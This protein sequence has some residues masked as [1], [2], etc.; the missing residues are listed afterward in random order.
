MT[1]RR[2]P[3]QLA[4]ALIA[5]F[6]I[7]ALLSD[8]L[9]VNPP[10][11]LNLERFFAPP[12]RVRFI[13]AQGKFHWRP[14]VC[15]YE[16]ADP[17]DVR[18]VEKPDEI[19]PLSFFSTGYEYRFMG[20]FPANR[21][22]V[23][24]GAGRTFYPWGA[25][26]L[27]RDVLAR[28]LAGART[29]MIVVIVGV[30]VYAV[31]GFVVGTIAGFLRGWVDAALMR[32]SE[33]VMAVPA[34]Y[35]ILAL[36]A[37]LPLKLSY[38]QTVWLVAG[39]I[40]S[41]TWPPLA[42]GIRGLVFQL[43]NAGYVESARAAGCTP[44]RIFRRHMLPALIPFGAA[45]TVI[46]APFFLLGEAVLSFLDIGFRDSGESWGSMLRSLKDPRVLTGFWWNLA[47]LALI[48]L[49][50]LCLTILSNY[51]SRDNAESQAFRP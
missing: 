34:L 29:S 35:L 28:V 20:L 8:F 4:L 3:F 37:L 38:W 40:A 5:V 1:A 21:H 18:Y 32:T 26:D 50:L 13:D 7:A 48:F 19:Y 33:F 22:L 17:L 42:R 41:V 14:F 31:L 46:A 47:P 23:G 2:L 36:R 45:Q 6:A 30:F 12:S 11:A 16:L 10:Q 24:T 27:G 51:L 43:R 15:A 44:A 9:S 25:D 49:T 39:T